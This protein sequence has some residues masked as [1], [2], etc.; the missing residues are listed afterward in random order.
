MTLENSFDYLLVIN[1]TTENNSL[2]YSWQKKMIV[3]EIDV[4]EGIDKP[5]EKLIKPWAF[6]DP[7]SYALINASIIDS[8]NGKTLTGLTVLTKNGFIEKLVPGNEFDVSKYKSINCEGKYLCP[9]LFDFHVHMTAVQGAT[10]LEKTMRMPQN[11]MLMRVGA[12]ARAMLERGFTT[13]R[14]CGGMEHYIADAIEDNVIIGPRSFYCNKAIGQTGGHADNR[15]RNVPGIAYETCDCH[16][17]KIGVVADGRA[18]CMRVAREHFRRGAS[19]IKIMSGGGVATPADQ[20]EHVQYTDDEI[21]AIVEVAE[22]VDSYVTAHAYTTRAIQRCIK[23]GVKGI[24]H[25]NMIDDETAKLMVE[26][27][28]FICPTLVTYKVLGSDQFSTFLP[29]DSKIKNS[30]ILKAGLQS[31]LTIKRNGVKMCFGSD[32]LGALS[33]YESNEFSIRSKVLEPAEI[34]QSATI[35]PASIMK[36]EKLI[37]QIAEGFYADILVLDKNPLEDITVLDKHEKYLLA[38]LKNGLVYHTKWEAFDSD[39]PQVFA[40]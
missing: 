13:V 6:P 40:A 3:P 5:L 32:L 36:V 7:T 34:L 9:G 4:N 10:E 31:L 26:K 33:G 30:I 14:D 1:Y 37:G 12:S 35:T 25:G 21:K 19:F 16:L 22:N 28:C 29:P 24:E 38:V 8:L 27:D 23:C 39:V 2:R 15:P 18:E 11:I 17:G 20:I